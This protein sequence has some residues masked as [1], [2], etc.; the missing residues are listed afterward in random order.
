MILTR[1]RVSAAILGGIAVLVLVLLILAVAFWSQR[2]DAEAGMVRYR[3][4]RL[5]G[6]THFIDAARDMIYDLGWEHRSEEGT[7]HGVRL[8]AIDGNGKRIEFDFRLGLF[9]RSVLVVPEDGSQYTRSQIA[10]E[11][12]RRMGVAVD[13]A[14]LPEPG[15]AARGGAALP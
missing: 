12:A 5:S 1:K 7:R 9:R 14:P 6:G 2:L 15:K 13:A 11:L 10:T 3:S 8:T 4:F